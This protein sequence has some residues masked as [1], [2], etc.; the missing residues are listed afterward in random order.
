MTPPVLKK[1]AFGPHHKGFVY[2]AQH[3][4]AGLI[5]IGFTRVDP[6]RRIRALQEACPE[7]LRW[8]GFYP[9]R[10]DEERRVH[11]RFAAD[12]ARGEWFR[13]SDA[14][15]AFI[16]EMCP[17]FNSSDAEEALFA[18]SLVQEIKRTVRVTRDSKLLW[19]RCLKVEGLK[20][21]FELSA[22]FRRTEIPSDTMIAKARRA[23]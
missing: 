9:T 7:V 15:L 3:G 18:V 11:Q 20:D 21:R 4:D 14:L 23:L 13:P 1:P 5:K 2:F 19:N 10:A 6:A 22:W 17:R 16:R 12:R 8:I